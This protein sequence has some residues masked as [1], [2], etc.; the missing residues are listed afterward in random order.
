MLLQHIPGV[1][2]VELERLSL[3]DD[4]PNVVK[5]VLVAKPG[6]IEGGKILPAQMVMVDT[7]S[8]DGIIVEI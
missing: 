1:L 4:Q 3:R 2:A 5:E 6:C 8:S 7:T